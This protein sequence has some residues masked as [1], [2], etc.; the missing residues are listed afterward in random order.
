MDLRCSICFD[1]S[2][3]IVKCSSKSCLTVVCKDCMKG[4]LLSC[5]GE[6]NMLPKCVN[7]NC[8]CEYVYNDLKY[9]ELLNIYYEILYKCLK[10]DTEFGQY[11]NKLNQQK[12]IDKFKK[13]KK[14]FMEKNYP[15][16]IQKIIDIALSDKLNKINKDNKR[17][18]E[19]MT[20]RANR[21]CMNML[22]KGTL[23][24]INI[25]EELYYKC[26]L[27]DDVYCMKCEGKG[28]REH[29][30]K[31]EDIDSINLINSHVKCPKCKLPIQK[32][33]GCNH[34]TC[35]N[36]NTHF[37]YRSGVEDGIGN[38]HNADI[39]LK[40]NYKPSVSLYKEYP[41]NI[42]T[43]FT[44]IESKEPKSISYEEV[45]NILIKMESSSE[46]DK[47]KKELAIAYSK[48]KQVLLKQKEYNKMM[49]TIQ[50]YHNEKKLDEIILQKII[51]EL[52]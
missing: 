24:T 22:C 28:S 47:L 23:N 20:N 37:E 15:K 34:M 33:E 49:V 17:L 32:S 18:F 40:E 39:K 43:L 42:I 4:Y 11:Q 51:D 8:N 3:D 30:C 36:C 26:N 38:H 7:R 2:N 27:C 46:L 50:N 25:N 9:N 35:A 14:E 29:K 1:E 13:E 31:Q 44:M 19:D 12:L 10:N 5:S 45:K 16:A 48:Y 21:K 6:V 52:K 41:Q